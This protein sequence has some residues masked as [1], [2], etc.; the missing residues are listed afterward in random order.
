MTYVLHRRLGDTF[1]ITHGG[2]EIVLR[3]VAALRDSIFQREL[4]MSQANFLKLFPDEEGFPFL[5]VDAD[6][7]PLATVRSDIE[8]GL[9]DF[10]ADATDTTERLASFHRVENTYLSTFQTLGGL[11]LLLGTV[12]LATVLMRNVLERRRE[13]ALLGAVGYGRGQ[14][15]LMAAAENTVLVVCGLAAGAVSAGLAIAPAVAER[16]GRIPL[17]SG[18]LLLLFSVFVV[19]LL[20]SIAA[21]GAATRGPL[22][23]AL[24][25]E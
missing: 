21:M 6:K 19:A 12:G 10:G 23:E 17:T 11:G 4:L 24:R 2:R 5:L 14:F 20:S 9:R 15:L 13:L 7:V 3:F 1:V 25:A 18:A 8:D 22:L 16:G